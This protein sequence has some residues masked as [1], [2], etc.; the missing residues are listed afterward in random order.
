MIGKIL[1]FWIGGRL[2]EVV[3]HGGS[4]V[5]I[6]QNFNETAHCA[7]GSLIKILYIRVLYLQ[8]FLL[9]NHLCAYCLGFD[10]SG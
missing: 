7:N 1:V 10:R 5:Y 4:T 8:E 6:N 3:A 2:W 9:K